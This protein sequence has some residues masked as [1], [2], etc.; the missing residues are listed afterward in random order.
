MFVSI[1]LIDMVPIP[2]YFQIKFVIACSNVINITF[3]FDKPNLIWM[4][5]IGSN[6]C[7]TVENWMHLGWRD[8]LGICYNYWSKFIL[9]P[10]NISLFFTQ[11]RKNELWT[12]I[13]LSFGF[14]MNHKMISWVQFKIVLYWVLVSYI[15]P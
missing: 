2:D 3:I 9:A 6:G 11:K 1:T 13:I 14:V 10:F 5:F 15:L 12:C 4:N 7:Y 8:C